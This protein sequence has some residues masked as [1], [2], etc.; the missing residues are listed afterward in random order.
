MKLH[1]ITQYYKEIV[2]TCVKGCLSKRKADISAIHKL[3]IM[4][5]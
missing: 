2:L 4:V 5:L 1:N 3:A